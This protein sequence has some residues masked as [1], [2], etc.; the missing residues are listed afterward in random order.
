MKHFYFA[1]VAFVL[2]G[3][4]TSC[5]DDDDDSPITDYKSGIIGKWQDGD[6][7]YASILVFDANTS[8]DADGFVTFIDYDGYTSKEKY[9]FTSSNKFVI[10]GSYPWHCTIRSM[11]KNTCTFYIDE[12]GK[13]AK[14]KR[15]E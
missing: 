3:L 13:E 6:G 4:F 9:S 10:S 7:E 1:L 15:I 5:G 12:E 11:T 14:L 8:Y 2:C